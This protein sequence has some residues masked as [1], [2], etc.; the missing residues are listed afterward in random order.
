MFIDLRYTQFIYEAITI[1]E[2]DMFEFLG[3]SL[4]AVAHPLCETRALSVKDE[5][6]C[7]ADK[8]TI[9]RSE[10][11]DDLDLTIWEVKQLSPFSASM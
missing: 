10:S 2:G 11:D 8:I 4:C 6:T 5:T 3:T 7:S 1:G 9:S